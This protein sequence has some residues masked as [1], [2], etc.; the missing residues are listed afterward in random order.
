LLLVVTDRQKNNFNN[1]FCGRTRIREQGQ[2]TGGQCQKSR[3]QK[4]LTVNPQGEYNN[5]PQAREDYNIR[6][7]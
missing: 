5:S 1:G 4:V 2:V 3:P 6:E 7:P